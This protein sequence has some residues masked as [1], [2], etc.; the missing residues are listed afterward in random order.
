MASRRSPSSGSKSGKGVRR[1]NDEVEGKRGLVAVPESMN[2]GDALLSR[3]SSRRLGLASK[4]S[5]PSPTLSIA[6]ARYRSWPTAV[7]DE[8]ITGGACRPD[9]QARSETP[10]NAPAT[11]TPGWSAPRVAGVR[12][13]RQHPRH[14][15]A[16]HVAP[17]R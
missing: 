13:S 2:G 5:A 12:P 11:S 15:P 7:T 1:N 9:D 17:P 10:T 6:A 14:P 16:S 4:S 3:R 8:V